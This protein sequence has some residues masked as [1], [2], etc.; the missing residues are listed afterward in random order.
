MIKHIEEKD[1]NEE[2]K[3][4]KVLVDFYATWCGPCKMLGLVLEKIE[5]EIDIPILKVDVDK[6]ENISSEYKIYSVPT[7]I[8]LNNGKEEKILSEQSGVRIAYRGFYGMLYYCRTDYRSQGY[9]VVAVS[10]GHSDRACAY[11]KGSVFLAVC[12]NIVGRNNLCGGIGN[13]I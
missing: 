11:H 6:T 12:R 8:L 10:A 7:L 13:G 1:F 5:K 9:A 3:K 4:G 2:I